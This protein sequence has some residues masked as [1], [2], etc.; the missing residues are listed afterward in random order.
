MDG[1]DVEGMRET[2]VEGQPVD[3]ERVP[4]SADDAGQRPSDENEGSER[5]V[6]V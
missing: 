4:E 5:Y 2:P 6:P 1:Q 3:D